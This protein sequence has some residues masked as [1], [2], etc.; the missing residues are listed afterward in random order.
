V[1]ADPEQQREALTLATKLRSNG[2]AVSYSLTAAKFNKQFKAAQQSK[3]PLAIVI[4]NEFPEISLKVLATRDEAKVNADDSIV[5]T[6]FQYLN[7]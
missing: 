4:G 7:Q 6:I 2:I 1:V 5:E 3:A